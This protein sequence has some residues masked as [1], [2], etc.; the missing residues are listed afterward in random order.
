MRY[1][2]IADD[3]QKYGPV[4]LQTLNQWAAESRVRPDHQLEVETTA[5]RVLASTVMGLNFPVPNGGGYAAPNQGY[6]PRDNMMMGDDGSGD[7]KS[8][9]IYGVL[10]LFCCPF[11]FSILAI[12]NANKARAKGNINANGPSILG[13]VGLVLGVILFLAR[14]GSFVRR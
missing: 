14:I 3:G 11:I 2:L 7:I 6:Y 10:G 12:V 9:W 5:Q 8:A 4:D 13:Y 1:Y